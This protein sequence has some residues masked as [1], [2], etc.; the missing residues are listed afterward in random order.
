MDNSKIAAW[1]VGRIPDD[2]FV[3]TRRSGSTARRSR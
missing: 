1:V 3:E 2:W